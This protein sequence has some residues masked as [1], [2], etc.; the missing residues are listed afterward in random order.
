MSGFG[1]VVIMWAFV[2]VFG[3]GEFME[4]V[5]LAEHWVEVVYLLY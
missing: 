1:D 4:E 5:E 2:F 3:I